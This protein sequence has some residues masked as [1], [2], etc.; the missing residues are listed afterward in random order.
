LKV[1]QATS[2]DLTEEQIPVIAL[3]AIEV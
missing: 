2:A 1:E 3:R